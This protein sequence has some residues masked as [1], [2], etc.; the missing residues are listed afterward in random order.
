MLTRRLRRVNKGRS[1]VHFPDPYIVVSIPLY[2]DQGFRTRVPERP[3]PFFGCFPLG[4]SLGSCQGNTRVPLAATV[5]PKGEFGSSDS[6]GEVIETSERRIRSDPP[7][8]RL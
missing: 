4:S 7:R 6:V 2:L 8:R 5:K 1:E 3:I